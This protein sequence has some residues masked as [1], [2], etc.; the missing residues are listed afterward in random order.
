MCYSFSIDETLECAEYGKKAKKISLKIALMPHVPDSSLLHFR[1]GCRHA[2]GESCAGMK[3]DLFA[4]AL[5]SHPHAGANSVPGML[6]GKCGS[7][8]GTAT[9]KTLILNW[10]TIPARGVELGI[11]INFS[12]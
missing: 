7:K 11:S 9:C 10:M 12:V 8:N 5:Q 2:G 4:S 3:R 1:Y 6:L